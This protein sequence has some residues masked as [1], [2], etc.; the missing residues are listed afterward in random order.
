MTVNDQSSNLPLSRSQIQFSCIQFQCDDI[1]DVVQVSKLP[2]LLF[3]WEQFS[4]IPVKIKR[5]ATEFDG[6][7]F[8]Q[9]NVVLCFCG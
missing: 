2:I 3:T 1:D 4:L 6:R 5:S 8:V 9:R 7:Y